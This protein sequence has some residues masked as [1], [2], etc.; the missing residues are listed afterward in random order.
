MTPPTTYYNL[1]Y[2]SY[3]SYRYGSDSCANNFPPC[4]GRIKIEK[5]VSWHS[6]TWLFY[7][8]CIGK[9]SL[10]L[11]KSDYNCDREELVTIEFFVSLLLI[12]TVNLPS[13]QRGGHPRSITG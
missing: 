1:P 13:H 10:I 12:P 3:Y 8:L 2:P 5:K 11:A 7:F 4:A 9:Q 6:D